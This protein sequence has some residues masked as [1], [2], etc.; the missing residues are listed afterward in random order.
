M[1]GFVGEGEGEGAG[2][3]TAFCCVVVAVTAAAIIAM[4]SAKRTRNFTLT[5][6]ERFP[7]PPC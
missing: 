6:F 7:S 3:A 4:R 1:G 2:F 5:G